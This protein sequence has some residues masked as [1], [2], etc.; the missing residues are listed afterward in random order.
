MHQ[1]RISYLLIAAG[2]LAGVGV[3]MLAAIYAPAFAREALEAN[4]DVPGIRG[5]YWTGLVGVWTV[6]ALFLL[7]LSEYFFVCVRIGKERSF[8]PENVKS[9]RRIA[10]YLAI[11]GILWIGAIFVPGLFGLPV[12]PA[13]LLF[14]LAS[15][16]CSALSVLAWCLGKLLD[17]AVSLQQENDL[18]V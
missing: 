4:A 10:L 17:R 1:K 2:A 12:G 7:A 15:M 18:T 5:L 8:C 14:L 16:A 13:C 3:L 9:L 11:D 6:A